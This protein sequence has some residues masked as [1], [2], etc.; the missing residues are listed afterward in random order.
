MTAFAQPN[1]FTAAREATEGYAASARG[2]ARNGLHPAVEAFARASGGAAAFGRGN[3]EAAAQ[4]AQAY[5]AGLQDLG[6]QYA[7]AVQG[8]T[9]H[10]VEGAG[11]FAGVTSLNDAVAL[12]AGLARASVERALGEGAKLQQAAL[13]LAERVHAPLARRAAAVLE[14]ARPAR[15]A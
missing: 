6:R 8:L 7:A 3:L 12:Q 11:A 9:R 13:T 2:P 10:A 14:Q 1:G 5:L 4:S 15:A